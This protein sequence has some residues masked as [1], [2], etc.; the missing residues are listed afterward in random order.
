MA[1]MRRTRLPRAARVVCIMLLLVVGC[2]NNHSEKS[3][4][5]NETPRITNSL[6]ME[7]VRIEP[8]EF[9]MGFGEKPLPRRLITRKGHFRNGD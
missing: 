6:G 7:L 9:A 5:G 8:G 2:G 1:T 4:P 3:E